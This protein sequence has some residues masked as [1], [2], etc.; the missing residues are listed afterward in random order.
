[1]LN[2]LISSFG[3]R[4]SRKLRKHAQKIYDE[5]LP[6]V[7]LEGE[8]KI[9]KENFSEIW[10][11][12]GF[13]SGEHMLEQLSQNP[14]VA[15]IGCEPFINGVAN[16]LASLSPTDYNRVRIWHE[17]VRYLLEKIP[18]LYFERTFIL[19][20]D[21]WPKKRHHQRRLITHNFIGQ[22]MCTL[23]AGAFL[24]IASDDISY[25]QQIQD[26]LYGY[27]GLILCDGPPSIDPLTWKDRP[28]TWPKTRYE[29]KALSRGKKCAYMVF[30]KEKSLPRS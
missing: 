13:G 7:K 17:D 27:P 4:K 24:H 3:R 25:V 11:E 20:P 30:Q 10:L 8:E 9:F 29:H 1:M 23:K 19:F 14:T 6:L 18:P 15:M 12:I 16:L 2:K 22:L 28:P 21:P 26:I 5:L